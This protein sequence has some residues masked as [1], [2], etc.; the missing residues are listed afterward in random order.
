[1]VKGVHKSTFIQKLHMLLHHVIMAKDYYSLCL[2][3]VMGCNISLS[4]VG[5]GRD[6]SYIHMQESLCKCSVIFVHVGAESL[7]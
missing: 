4:D 7:K 3:E 2:L 6:Y 1:M 5:M